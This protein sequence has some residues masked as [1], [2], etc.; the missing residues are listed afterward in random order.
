MSR[1]F[2]WIEDGVIAGMA[3]PTSSS[4]ELQDLRDKGVR[5]IV[6]LTVTPILRPLIEEFG[7]EYLHLPVIDF[8]A[9][10]LEQIQD[11]AVFVERMT[12]N[13]MPV[14]V[15]CGAGMGRTGT[16]LA[17]YLVSQGTAATEALAKV[18][19]M[20]P[21]SVETNDQE[22]VIREYER[23]VKQDQNRRQRAKTR[24]KKKK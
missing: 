18:R 10:T 13:K 3:R 1:N 17:C 23:K 8:S 6:S 4:N 2:S 9:P 24:K 21:G 16:M 20:R 22:Q 5:A 11:F 15:H 19:R 14:A 12:Q 7:F